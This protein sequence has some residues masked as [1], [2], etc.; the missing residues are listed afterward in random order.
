MENEN[1]VAE[2]LQQAKENRILN[3]SELV[4]R[5]EQHFTRLGYREKTTY[6]L[7]KILIVRLD[8]VGDF[9]LTSSAI[10]AIRENFPAADITLVVSNRTF[11]LAQLCPYVNEVL[12]FDI[13]FNKKNNLEIISKI[14]EFAKKNLCDKYFDISFDFV[15]DFTHM[16][17]CYISGARQRCGF[18]FDS[19][20]KNPIRQLFFNHSIFLDHDKFNHLCERNLFL[21]K[22]VGLKINSTKIEIWFDKNDLYKAQNILGNFGEGRLKVAVGI[23]AQAPERKYPVEKYLVAFKEIISKGAS[24]II[25]GGPSEFDDA[26]FLEENLPKEYVLNVAKLKVS[27]RVTAAVIS[28]TDMYIGNDTGTQHI[29]AALKKPVIV[30]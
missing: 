1:I 27:W 14:T 22:S 15:A 29:A 28:Q 3:L 11:A 13:N 6:T 12:N 8:G 17:M 10:R 21:L 7:T 24:I 2:I 23:G 16:F 26:K 9:I 5:L 25:L 18:Y 4:R 30:L 20:D 19:R